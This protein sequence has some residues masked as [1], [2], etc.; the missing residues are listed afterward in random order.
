MSD[1][2]PLDNVLT[3]FMLE[4]AE[5]RGRV[6]RLGSTLDTILGRY[7]YPTPV[8]RALGELVVVAAILSSSLKTEGILTIQIRGKGAVPLLVVDA[9]HGGALRG[10]ADVAPE[11]RTALDAAENTS[12][13][14]LFGD[15]AYLAI[16]FDPGAGMQRYQG[17]V[18]LEGATIAEA[19]LGY[20]RDSQQI[21][22]I[23]H[24]AVAHAKHWSA[25]GI[26]LERMPQAKAESDSWP[27]AR[28]VAATVSDAELLD[29][30][31]DAPTLLYRLFH[32]SGV[33]VYDAQGL[34]T[35]CRCSRERIEQMLLS[36]PTTD[37]A[38]MVV[39]GAATVH[40][41]FCNTEQRF[42]AEQLGLG[43]LN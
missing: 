6:V 29:P 43:G 28:A 25:A 16:T 12:L 20:F 13:S 19:L 31:L 1:T 14:D 21:E 26:L 17:V 9:T 22:V 24:L 23:L 10:Y 38:D 15:G 36:M 40:C 4:N 32:E 7:D 37:R 34:T 42:T 18:A 35:H 11:H 8:A 2:L 33:W 30:L 39:D 5:V 27:Y 41:Q 3:P